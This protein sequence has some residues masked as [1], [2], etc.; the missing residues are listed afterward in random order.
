MSACIKSPS[1]KKI[2]NTRIPATVSLFV[3]QF[4][5]ELDNQLK[6]LQ[7]HPLCVQSGGRLDS[8]EKMFMH[9]DVSGASDVVL[10]YW[11]L[12]GHYRIDLVFAMAE[13]RFAINMRPISGR[14]SAVKEIKDSF[15]K[16][17]KCKTEGSYTDEFKPV[18]NIKNDPYYKPMAYNANGKAGDWFPIGWTP[19]LELTFPRATITMP[20]WHADPGNLQDLNLLDALSLIL[21]RFD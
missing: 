11:A 1:D 20:N 7:L 5:G 19:G 14:K 4:A 18:K 9:I 6:R 17:I 2:R 10:S 8:R 13:S 3:A 15:I 16:Y 12:H 21:K